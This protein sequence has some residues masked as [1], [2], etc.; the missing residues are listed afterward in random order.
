MLQSGSWTRPSP[1]IARAR[2][3]REGE[4]RQGARGEQARDVADAPGERRQREGRGEP[5]VRERVVEARQTP[6]RRRG[7]TGLDEAQPG[8]EAAAVAAAEQDRREQHPGRRHRSRRG[9]P[10][11]EPRRPRGEPERARAADAPRSQHRLH[12]H[13]REQRRGGDHP[14][15][16][17][18]ERAE[19]RPHERGEHGVR[20]RRKNEHPGGDDGDLRE[21]L[22]KARVAAP[23]SRSSRA[24]GPRT[25][26]GAVREQRRPCLVRSAR[27]RASGEAVAR[28]PNA[29]EAIAETRTAP[30][31]TYGTIV[32]CGNHCASNP[33]TSGPP[34]NPL[35]RATAARR[36][37]V[38]AFEPSAR[39]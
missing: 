11:E 10:A 20:D 13:A 12:E 17:H 25:P 22:R 4:R 37:P 8:D 31:T 7:R 19:L 29:T 21:A 33:V 27:A 26:Y 30:C 32:G 36:A 23:G 28:G 34:P 16:D 39:S 5:D 6:A 9:G 15:E 2:R 24:H 38:P 18:G 14:R 35:D 3:G 1:R